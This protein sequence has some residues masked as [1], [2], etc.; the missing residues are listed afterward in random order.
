[1]SKP[2][3]S[4]AVHVPLAAARHATV[5]DGPTFAVLRALARES[6]HEA[7]G[8]RLLNDHDQPRSEGLITFGRALDNPTEA[9]AIVGTLD[10]QPVGML[11]A[12]VEPTTDGPP[13]AAITELFV[14]SWAR[15]LGVGEEL[16]KL[17]ERWALEVGCSGLDA[18]ALPG[19]RHTKNFFE[20]HGLVARAITVHRDFS[21]TE[22][23]M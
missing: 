1:M 15:E 10:G 5:E 13:I 16:M 4:S 20:S 17:L 9:S 7:R 23:T 18:E 2:V 6:V 3:G 14:E 22:G 8:G 12:R 19:D 21:P 11:L